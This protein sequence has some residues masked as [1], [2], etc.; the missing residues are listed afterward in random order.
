MYGRPRTRCFS[1]C[2]ILN[3]GPLPF[4][5]KDSARL[6]RKGVRCR[7]QG[8]SATSAASLRSFSMEARQCCVCVPFTLGRPQ[9]RRRKPPAHL[10]GGS[11]S[12]RALPM[13]L[14]AIQDGCLGLL[15]ADAQHLPGGNRKATR[16]GCLHCHY[17]SHQQFCMPLGRVVAVEAEPPELTAPVVEPG[18]VADVLAVLPLEPLPDVDAPGACCLTVL[19]ETSQH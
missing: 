11:A 2:L 14:R 5:A 7:G 12:G 4:C 6:R 10:E 13:S 9:A 1:A 19:V 17:S 3:P 15:Y 18:V 8:M 16:R